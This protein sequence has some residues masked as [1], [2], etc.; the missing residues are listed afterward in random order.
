MGVREH[1]Q[2][3][4]ID[5]SRSKH[6]SPIALTIALLVAYENMSKNM[7]EIV[8][9][10]RQVNVL[11]DFIADVMACAPNNFPNRDYL[12]SEEQMTLDR[13][14]EKLFI[15]VSSINDHSIPKQILEKCKEKLLE[16]YSH[17]RNEENDSGIKKLQVALHL[18]IRI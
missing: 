15:D 11:K 17:Y 16:A 4:M 12:H 9:S 10:P 3:R 8:I 7:V 1:C 14:F 6:Q 2:L 5:S 18:L 13:A